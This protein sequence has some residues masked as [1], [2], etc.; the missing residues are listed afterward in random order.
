MTNYEA[1][2]KALADQ[3][4][5]LCYDAIDTGKGRLSKPPVSPKTG[6]VCAKNDVTNFTTLAEALV[7]A[8]RFDLPGVGFVFT[9]G[10]VC[11][12]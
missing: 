3:P 10:F 11:V 7:G 8:E 12:D 5:W 9:E 1:I 6:Q 4:N 2:P